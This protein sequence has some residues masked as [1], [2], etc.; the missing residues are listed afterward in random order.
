MNVL[1]LMVF[2]ASEPLENRA[3]REPLE[4]QNA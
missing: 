2:H 4:V 1:F 3:F